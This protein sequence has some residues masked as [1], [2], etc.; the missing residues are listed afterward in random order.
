MQKEPKIAA[1]E[2]GALRFLADESSSREVVVAL[3]LS[4]LLLKMVRMPVG[5]DPVTFA[6]PLVAALSPFPDEP[7]LVSC[8]TVCE[9]P[10]SRLVLAAALP[11]G[12]TEDLATALDAAKV[13]VVKIDALFLGALRTAWNDIAPAGEGEEAARRLVIL[14]TG[15]DRVL[16]VLDGG[17]PVSIHALPPEVDVEREK[18]LALLEAEDFNGAK[19]LVATVTR[20]VSVDDALQGIRERTAEAQSLNVLPESWRHV[21]AETRFKA[22]LIR[23]LAVAVGVWVLVMGTLFGVPIAYNFCTDHVKSLS[24]RHQAQYKA[25]ADKKAKTMLVKKY[26]DFSRGA[27]EMMKAV[28]DRLEGDITLS[29]FEF[30]REKCVRVKG[31]ATDKG[32]IYKFKDNLAEMATEGGEPIFAR[33]VLGSV[34]SQKDGTQRF[35]LECHHEEDD[36]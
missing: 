12:A 24:R 31:E 27:L 11:E 1:Y 36:E 33:V 32:S 14:T 23:H 5:E 22:K 35:D 18:A 26:S 16:V 29:G 25:V 30:T 6:T 34:H 13:S 17:E 8:E 21:L 4:R 7:L 20:E 10:D 15:E 9:T 19:D 3:P 28:S 2:S